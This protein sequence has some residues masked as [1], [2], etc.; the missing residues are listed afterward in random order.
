MPTVGGV[1]LI[2]APGK[3]QL[4]QGC[5]L[6]RGCSLLRWLAAVGLAMLL[7]SSYTTPIVVLLCLLVGVVVGA[8]M[9]LSAFVKTGVLCSYEFK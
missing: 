4:E 3:Q 1:H 8:N 6:Y 2:E 5:D 7:V 9:Q